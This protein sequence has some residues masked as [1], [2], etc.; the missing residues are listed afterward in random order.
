LLKV[1]I[2]VHACIEVYKTVTKIVGEYHCYCV[3][4]TKIILAR[5]TAYVEENIAVRQYGFL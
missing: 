1:Y 2:I 3:N 4:S 5:L